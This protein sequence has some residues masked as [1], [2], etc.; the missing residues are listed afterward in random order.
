MDLLEYLKHTPENT[1]LNVVK[2]MIE[3]GGSS[4]NP[5]SI[6]VVTGTADSIFADVDY[7]KL[8]QAVYNKNATVYCEC[9]GSVLGA[10]IIKTYFKSDEIILYADGG[11]VSAANNMTQAFEISY[12]SNGTLDFYLMGQNST[13]TNLI[14]YASQIPTTLTIIWHPVVEEVESELEPAPVPAPSPTPSIGR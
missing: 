13:I 3:N 2:S 4:S 12:S 6:Q 1:N 9:D 14:S 7:S 10:G 5:N 11:S 8:C